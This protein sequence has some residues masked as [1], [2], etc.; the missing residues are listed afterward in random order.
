MTLEELYRIRNEL[1]HPGPVSAVIP[2]DAT[3]L[4]P[5]YTDFNPATA[6]RI[7]LAVA[8]ATCT[9]AAA[10]HTSRPISG[11]YEMPASGPWSAAAPS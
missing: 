5:L 11:T 4:E 9:L 8:Q 2:D 3:E 6:M 7:V 10:H 1:V